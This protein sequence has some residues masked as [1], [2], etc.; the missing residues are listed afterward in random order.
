MNT[1]ES[2]NNHGNGTDHQW[3]SSIDQDVRFDRWI[4]FFSAI[5]L[6]LATIGTAWCGYQATRWSGV[7]AQLYQEASAL[8]VEASQL[9]IQALQVDSLYVNLFVSWASAVSQ[10]NQLLADFLL[11]RFPPELKA[12]TQAWMDLK[13]ME[14]ADAPPTPFNMPGY[15][16]ELRDDAEFQE[17]EAKQLFEQANAANET[18]DRYVLQTVIFASVL[19]FGGISGKFKSRLVDILMLI[20]ASVVLVAGLVITLSFPIS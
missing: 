11:E 10:E 20:L 9:S 16:I 3:L 2:N 5:V 13:P 4:E 7:Q 18:S 1:E 8:K 6:A 14:N 12:A 15:S 17:Q 19:F